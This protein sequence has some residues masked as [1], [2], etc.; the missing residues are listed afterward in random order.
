MVVAKFPDKSNL[1]EGLMLAHRLRVQFIVWERH[2]DRIMGH[3]SEG[4]RGDYKTS[5]ASS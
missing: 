3:R 5:V 2:G 4:L 1:K